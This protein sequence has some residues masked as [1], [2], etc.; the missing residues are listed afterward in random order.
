MG[1]KQEKYNAKSS[2]G[3]YLSILQLKFD[4]DTVYNLITTLQ[5]DGVTSF[6]AIPYITLTTFSALELL[7]KNTSI[8]VPI[9]NAI[10]IQDVRFKLKIFEDGYSKSKRMLLNIDYLQDQIFMNKLRFDFTKSWNIHQNLGVYADGNKHIVGNTQYNYYLLQDNRFLKKS[11]EDVAAAYAASPDSFDLNKQ[12]GMDCYNY[13][14]SCG[15]II[16]SV[17]S[18]LKDFDTPVNILSKNSVTKYCYADY[19]S[20]VVSMLFP[21]GEDGKGMVLYLLH[22]LSTMNFLLFVLN[23]YEKDDYG[24]WLKINYVAYYYS[25]HKLQDL[26]QYL[27]QNKL[28]TPKL[29]SYFSEIDI[30]NTPYLNSKFRNYVMHSKLIDKDGNM[31]IDSD[32]VD[33]TKL[34]FGLVETCFS[35]LSYQE[36]KFAITSEM[37][38]ISG[39]LSRWL[40]TDLLHFEPFCEQ[41]Q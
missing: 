34:L 5:R 24:W 37:M 10:R 4:C 1:L 33:K 41:I 13:A 6:G 8:K 11:L 2:S 26:Q 15:Q 29:A 40:N 27:I 38:R 17:C 3:D 28:M 21:S 14:Y 22:V 9:S 12:A 35:G 36:V 39:I 23:N 25:V 30:D 32:K 18:G 31:V 20:N 7:A 16:G 19:N